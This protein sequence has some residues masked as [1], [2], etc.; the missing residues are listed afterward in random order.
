MKDIKEDKTNMQP[1]I[2][3]TMCFDNSDLIKTGVEYNYV[4]REYGRAVQKAGGQPLFLDPTIDPLVAAKLC[5]GIVI[6]GGEDIDP[7]LYNQPVTSV[8]QLEPRARTDWERQLIDACDEWS[9]PILGICYG[10]QLL[11]VHYGGTLYQDIATDL[12]SQI[13]HGAS[14]AAAYHEIVFEQ[15]FLGY[16]SGERTVVA[17]RHHQAVRDVAPGFSVVARSSDGS[18]EAIAGRGHVG[19]QWHAESDASAQK[20]YG[21]FVESCTARMQPSRA[22]RA[23][24][25]SQRIARFLSRFSK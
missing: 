3:I 16:H 10:E 14:S 20:I 7:S 15:N 23:A 22:I 11:N 6:S 12:H 24:T 13:D 8:G 17:A 25:N 19:V 5:D 1:V 2:G 21:A 18:I 9:R 4:R